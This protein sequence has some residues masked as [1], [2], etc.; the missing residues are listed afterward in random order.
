M[1]NIT[2]ELK[3]KSMLKSET[4]LFFQKILEESVKSYFS[5]TKSFVKIFKHFR[6]SDKVK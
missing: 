5:I 4:A 6:L 3:K 2:K 1:R